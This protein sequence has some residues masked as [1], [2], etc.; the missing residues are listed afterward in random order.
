MGFD[1]FFD[2]VGD[3]ITGA[4]DKVGDIGSSAVDDAGNIFSGITGD[5]SNLFSG[6]GKGFSSILGGL[7]LGG[8]FGGSGDGDGTTNW[9]TFLEYGL[10]AVGIIIL[11]VLIKKLV[12]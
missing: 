4:V 10:I 8:L 7:G 3:G 1:S 5:A 2:S 12:A 9:S 11:A 6:L